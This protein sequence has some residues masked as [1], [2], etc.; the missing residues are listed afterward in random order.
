V[1]L[2]TAKDHLPVVFVLQG[3]VFANVETE[4]CILNAQLNFIVQKVRSLV[5]T[6]LEIVEL[7][8]LEIE[9]L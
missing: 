2:E 3:F 4:F 8:L 5:H 9:E 7:H 1:I 6:D